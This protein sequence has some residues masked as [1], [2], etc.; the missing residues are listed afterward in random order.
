[1]YLSCPGK[2]NYSS[3]TDWRVMLLHVQVQLF[4]LRKL[5]RWVA[6]RLFMDLSCP[7]WLRIY[8]SNPPHPPTTTTI[9]RLNKNG[10]LLVMCFLWDPCRERTC[11]FVQISSLVYVFPPAYINSRYDTAVTPVAI[12]NAPVV[13]E[14]EGSEFPT[15]PNLSHH[16]CIVKLRQAADPGH[17]LCS[18]A[19][20]CSVCL[21]DASSS[22]Q[23][24]ESESLQW[25]QVS[26]KT[27]TQQTCF[28]LSV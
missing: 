15:F 18:G 23:I 27:K 5:L 2:G 9:R 7:G 3:L 25:S 14:V 21:E 8:T 17:K 13:I 28:M 16:H 22:S 24:T 26:V 10:T 6:K 20:Q 4:E 11:S 1:M 12:S 19:F